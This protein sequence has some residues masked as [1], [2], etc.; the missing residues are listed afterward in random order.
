MFEILER[1]RIKMSEKL[2]AGPIKGYKGTDKD[3]KCRGFQF[4]IGENVLDNNKPLVLCENGFHFCQ[5]PSGPYAYNKY[6]RLFEI[7]AY[8]VLESGFEPGADYKQ[9][10]RKIVFVREVVVTGNRNTGDRNTGHYN[11]GHWNTGYGN[12]G[13]SNTGNRNT[14]NRN[15]GYRNTGNRNTG[16]GNTGDRNTGNRNTG[17]GN[18]TDYCAGSLCCKEQPIVLFDKPTKL[19][20]KEIDWH[21]V[22]NLAKCLMNDDDF[23]AAPFLSI[24]N[25]TKSGIKKLHKA[26]IARRKALKENKDE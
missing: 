21:L 23:D 20:R 24:P 26:H 6:D 18:A 15:T 11:T 25:A 4:Q 12:T 19:S 9:V 13:H 8:D 2:I 1:R 7:E 16:Y 17:D 5:Q 14:G 22:N 10:C 3:M